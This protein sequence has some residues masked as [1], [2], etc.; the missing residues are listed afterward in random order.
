MNILLTNDDGIL[1]EGIT[2]LA[3]ALSAVAKVYLVAP[4]DQKSACGH[5][6]TISRYMTAEEMNLP[7]AAGAIAVDGT[8]ADC[9][10][11][12]LYMLEKSGVSIDKVVSGANHGPNL[13]TDTIYSGTVSAA[14]EGA[15]NEIPSIAVSIGSKSPTEFNA[16]GKIAVMA[17]E[18]PLDIHGRS[19]TLNINLPHRPWE[20]IKGIKVTKLGIMA[21]EELYDEAESA[22]GLRMFAY[23]GKAVFKDGLLAD[24]DI[25]GY[26]AGYI[27]ITP[28]QFDMTDHEGLSRLSEFFSAVCPQKVVYEDF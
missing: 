6:I 27:T 19:V 18:M 11:L 24:T 20:D 9:V 23:A 25:E 14:V 17:A 3:K 13:G 21:Y 1:A 2:A 8:P 15:M 5:G 16:A 26:K 7:Y 4:R 22:D 10:K 12:G 28:L